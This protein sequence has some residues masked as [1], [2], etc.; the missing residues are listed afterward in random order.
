MNKLIKKLSLVYIFFLPFYDIPKTGIGGVAFSGIIMFVLYILI[1]IE[2]I[3]T[4]RKIY[5]KPIL[6][7]SFLPLIIVFLLSVLINNELIFNKTINH[8]LFYVYSFSIYTIGSYLIIKR[9]GAKY[10]SE[11]ISV[12]IIIVVMIGF[13]ELGIFFLY[14]WDSYA[15]F[16]NHGQNI[17]VHA[18][19]P[20]LRST[21]NEPSHIAM[22]L[23]CVFPIVLYS[24]NKIA[25]ILSGIAILLTLSAS[26][27]VGLVMAFLFMIPIILL[28]LK[29]RGI[30]N[31]VLA[32]LFLLPIIYFIYPT[33]D[34]LIFKVTNVQAVDSTRYDA[35]IKS[36]ELFFN[37]SI[38]GY[39][40]ASYYYFIEQ[41]VFSW[42]L[43]ILVEAGI[44]GILALFIFFIPPIMIIHKQKDKITIFF[45]LAFLIQMVAMNHYYLPGIWILIAFIYAKNIK[46]ELKYN[47]NITHNNRTQ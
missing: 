44:L 26:A 35:W 3:M 36:I 42:Y 47:E 32:L 39:G 38:I 4:T 37:S 9:Y 14:G 23:I 6:L 17:G 19:I 29:G 12:A 11:I 7:A 18:G 45:I 10:F 30:K 15:N 2:S 43:Q 46:K 28:N 31:V 16:L 1:T 41:G 20:R 8:I 21:F 13:V 24:K 33:I 25:I 5:I 40:P 34:G 27:F 22:F